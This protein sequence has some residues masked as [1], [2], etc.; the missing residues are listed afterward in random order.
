MSGTGARTKIKSKSKRGAMKLRPEDV[1]A[2]GVTTVHNPAAAP[3][4]PDQA[5]STAPQRVQPSQQ[6]R[7][8]RFALGTQRTNRI[9]LRDR[10]DR[11]STVITRPIPGLPPERV[12][13]IQDVLDVGLDAEAQGGDTTRLDADIDAILA[14]IDVLTIAGDSDAG[15]DLGALMTSNTDGLKVAGQPLPDLTKAS[16]YRLNK[17]SGASEVVVSNVVL[18]LRQY[19]IWDLKNDAELAEL[20]AEI[21]REQQ[22]RW[23]KPEAAV[24]TPAQWIARQMIE[25]EDAQNELATIMESG[26][27]TVPG[28]QARACLKFVKDNPN[29]VRNL[30]S[31]G[32]KFRFADNN[33]KAYEGGV[34]MDSTNTISMAPM[35]QTPADGY[36]RLFVHETGHASFQKDLLG[37]PTLTLE[38]NKGTAFGALRRR[39]ELAQLTDPEPDDGL[40][41]PPEDPAAEMQRLEDWVRKNE[42]MS[43]WHE[44]PK[45]AQDFY[46]SWLVLRENNGRYLYGQDHGDGFRPDDRRVYQANTFTEFCAETFMQTATSTLTPW[47]DEL[48]RDDTVPQRVK[49]AWAVAHEIVERLGRPIVSTDMRPVETAPAPGAKPKVAFR[50]GQ[51]KAAVRAEIEREAAE[52]K[53]RAEKPAPDTTDG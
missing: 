18:Y 48:Y 32:I 6:N 16:L 44:L 19:G 22:A 53:A 26:V 38:W 24:T 14:E 33:A 11:I 15:A 34:F 31:R 27:S 29:Y 51:R 42:P 46:R 21:V 8:G 36:L 20:V 1:A 25:D 10:L 12:A 45:D 28:A 3:P 47:L 4:G 30:R 23:G 50:S 41:R 37:Q 40:P 39:M 13:E 17:E 52:K 49:D 35:D 2:V 9:P 7:G 5:T 43:T